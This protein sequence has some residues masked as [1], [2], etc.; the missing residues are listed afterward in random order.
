MEIEFRSSYFVYIVTDEERSHFQA[1][2]TTSLHNLPD[3][4][5]GAAAAS[6]GVYDRLLY[7]EQHEEMLTAVKRETELAFL[8]QRKLRKLVSA[9]NPQLMFLEK[10]AG[11][12][13]I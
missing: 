1:G 9:A 5:T 3:A 4:R 11:T 12:P 2:V 10:P 6:A 8:S 13:G 7:Y